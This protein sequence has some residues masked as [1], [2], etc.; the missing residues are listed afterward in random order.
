MRKLNIW[1]NTLIDLDKL[2]LR[3]RKEKKKNQHKRIFFAALAITASLFLFLESRVSKWWNPIRI[4]T[5]IIDLFRSSSLVKTKVAVI[6]ANNGK[7]NTNFVPVSLL[8][9]EKLWNWFVKSSAIVEK[10]VQI[11]QNGNQSVV[12][13]RKKKRY[14]RNLMDKLG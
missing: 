5:W 4:D 9:R 14:I 2:L 11:N 8:N 12:K 13:H 6:Y 7:L 1:Q 10:W 3:Q